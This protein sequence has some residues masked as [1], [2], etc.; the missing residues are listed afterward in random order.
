MDLHSVAFHVLGFLCSCAPDQLFWANIYAFLFHCCSVLSFKITTLFFSICRITIGCWNLY[1]LRIDSPF[2]P[3][4]YPRHTGVSPSY[5]IIW[6]PQCK[7]TEKPFSRLNTKSN[8]ESRT[9]WKYSFMFSETRRRLLHQKT[10]HLTIHPLPSAHSHQY[11]LGG[12]TR[13]RD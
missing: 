5:R 3:L 13:A 12:A 8:I 1:S 7:N 4:P 9:L 6:W 10:V 11:H 2:P